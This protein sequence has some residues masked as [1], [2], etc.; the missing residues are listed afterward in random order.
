MQKKAILL[1]CS[2]FAFLISPFSSFAQEQLRLSTEYFEN[3]HTGW[4][5]SGRTIEIKNQG[6][7]RHL[8]SKIDL[9][10]QS[11]ADYFWLNA[12]RAV[13]LAH[14]NEIIAERFSLPEGAIVGGNSMSKS[15]TALVVGQ[16]IC[17]GSIDSINDR[18]DIYAPELAGTSWGDA[19][20]RELLM[21][22]SGGYSTRL[23]MNGHPN[24]EMRS[25]MTLPIMGN[26]SKPFA[27]ILPKYD[28]RFAQPG[29]RFV[30]SNA[31]T[32]ALGLVLKGATGV[33]TAELFGNVWEKVGAARSGSWL[34]NSSGETVTYMGFAADPH[35]WIRLGLFLSERRKMDDCLGR[36]IKDATSIQIR[37]RTFND[38]RD[39]GYQFWTNCGV[40]INAFCMVG[41]L[42]QLV[43]INE[44]HDLV[45]YVHSVSSRWGGI[46]HWSNL[47][48]EVLRDL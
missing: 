18:A 28:V 45:L 10:W 11:R 43:L 47:F 9:E 17:D 40:S 26:R 30:Y 23:S 2:M 12:T 42:G 21:M 4:R 22:S 14:G 38:H 8:T 16:A 29:A 33:E 46:N 32:T 41:A 20:I 48:Y 13:V 3:M 27:E 39:Y 19:S 35:D 7:S 1:G 15:V 6:N 24:V 44:D 37:Y 25:E 5:S 34:I 36:Y 31:D